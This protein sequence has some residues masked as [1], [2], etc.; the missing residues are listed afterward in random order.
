MGR[1]GCVEERQIGVERIGLQVEVIR[2]DAQ[3]SRKLPDCA[4]ENVRTTFTDVPADKVYGR[5]GC[6]ETVNP[7]PPRRWPGFAV[8]VPVL[9][10][11]W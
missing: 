11:G 9:V 1:A 8:G 3:L 2:P 6:C 7:Y 4:G 5:N 10:R